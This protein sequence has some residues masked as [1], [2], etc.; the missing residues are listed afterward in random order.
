M[1]Q[2]KRIA[3]NTIVVI[4]AAGKGTRMGRSDLCKVC[5]EIDSLPAINRV[6]DTFRKQRFTRFLLVVGEKAGQV[7]HTVGK[8]NES[9]M[10]VY[11]SPQLGTGHAG[12]IAA[13]ALAN[14][15][16]PASL[17]AIGQL[18]EDYPEVS[19]RRALEEAQNRCR[20]RE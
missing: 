20:K 12:R 14:I 6:I 18:A 8:D 17:E 10:Y 19:T 9:V 11:Q 7:L 1:T 4:L 5:F 16:D 3:E 15:A 13:E 2:S